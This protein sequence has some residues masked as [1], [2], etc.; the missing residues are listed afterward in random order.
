MLQQNSY[1]TS[2]RYVKWIFKNIN[3]TIFTYELFILLILII[4]NLLNIDFTLVNI[5][6]YFIAI[7]I[8]L[9]LLK[10]EQH[11]KKF[12]VTK[13]V[14]RLIYT[15][16]L[17]FI[18]INVII[19]LDF[20]ENNLFYYNSIIFIF[21]YLSFIFTFFIYVIN[22]P[23]EKIV[24]YYYLNKAK[25]K[26]KANSRLKVI[27]ITGSYGKTS[28]KNILNEI[29]SSKFVTYAT[30]KSFNTPYGIMTSINN[31]LDKFTDVFIAEMGACKLNDINELCD[32][33]HP[34]YGIITT[35]GV[36]HLETFKS[37]TNIQKGK[38]ELIERLPSD[39]VG[40]LNKDDPNQTSY[41]IK[42]N[43][44]IIWIGIDNKDADIYA[45][46]IKVSNKGLKFD[47]KFKGDKKSYT[48]ET[49][50]LGKHNVYNILSSIAL[51]REFGI[52][53]EKLQRAVK[54]LKPIEHRLELKQFGD[55]YIIDDAYNS[56][57]VGSKSAVEVLGMM[58]GK[59]IIVTPG[60]IE[61]GEKQY[62]LNKKFGEYIAEV[63]DEV[64]LVGEKQTKPIYDGLIEKK[65][66]KSNIHIL[67]DVKDAFKL[68]NKL[69]DKETYVLL[70]NDL[71]DIFNEK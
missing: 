52:E 66:N 34:K 19:Y 61:L 26:L 12:V 16:L 43:C 46:N 29:L 7:L 25:N 28:S 70:E 38:F 56:N 50:L 23:V 68:I 15:T 71:P 67:N 14:R 5:I 22:I 40:I 39:G 32:I 21:G 44:K 35:I 45:E 24:Y 55:V 58:P 41:N 65:Y 17:I 63:C 1:N 53:I 13:R 57:P 31:E 27:G 8:E 49:I 18:F 69:K 4:V 64:I 36:A 48:F 9:K 6:V 11:K 20:N 33:V 3:K 42:N 60:M 30:P 54:S 2:D 47:V 51:G 37:E 59:K 62:E 10:K